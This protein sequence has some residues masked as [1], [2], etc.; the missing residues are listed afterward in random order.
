[1]SGEEKKKTYSVALPITGVNYIDVEA[2]SEEA[3]IDK[4]LSSDLS[5]D[6][7]EEWEPHRR[8]INGNVF[9]GRLAEAIAEEV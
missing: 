3:A 8:V 9:Y 4:A 5:F 2:E 1:M 7:V 6:S